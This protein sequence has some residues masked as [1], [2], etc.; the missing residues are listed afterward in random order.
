LYPGRATPAQVQ[1][2]LVDMLERANKL[3]RAPEFYDTLTNN[4][5]TNIVRHIN[6]LRPGQIPIDLRVVLPGHSDHMAY[7]L[8]LLNVEGP[9]E[10]VRANAKINLLAELYENAPDFSKKIRRQ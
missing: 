7:N 3:Q 6:K 1:N 2:L 9:F 4:C 5:T 8:G 10:E